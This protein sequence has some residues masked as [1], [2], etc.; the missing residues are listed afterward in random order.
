MSTSL[1]SCQVYGRGKTRLET[2]CWHT[3]AALP[4]PSTPTSARAMIVSGLE[5]AQSNI[6]C[7]RVQKKQFKLQYDGYARIN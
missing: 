5:G 7:K 1:C 6:D 2:D 4:S 3:R